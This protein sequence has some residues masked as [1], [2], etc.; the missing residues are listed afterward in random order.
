MTTIAKIIRKAEK[1]AQRQADKKN[2][3]TN[4]ETHNLTYVHQ[5]LVASQERAPAILNDGN[6]AWSSPFHDTRP[7]AITLGEM[8]FLK[9]SDSTEPQQG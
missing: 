8:F 5:Q 4:I 2:R 6:L 3:K 1:K 7:K 9:E